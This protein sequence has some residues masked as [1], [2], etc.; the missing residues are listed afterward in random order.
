V[1]AYS[2][3]VLHNKA[4]HNCLHGCSTKPHFQGFLTIWS[5]TQPVSL[6]LRRLTSWGCVDD[7]SSIE[8]LLVWRTI[9]TWNLKHIVPVGSYAGLYQLQ[10]LF[11][12]ELCERIVFR[13][14]ET[15]G[16]E[17]WWP[18]SR[19]SVILAFGWEIGG[20]PI[21]RQDN[22]C[23]SKGSNPLL[24][25]YKSAVLPLETARTELGFSFDIRRSTVHGWAG[26]TIRTK[27]ELCLSHNPLPFLLRLPHGLVKPALNFINSPSIY[28]IALQKRMRSFATKFMSFIF[29]VSMLCIQSC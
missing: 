9:Y 22:W 3:C 8:R 21:N 1:R 6:R 28:V 29:C 5:P 13:E 26:R 2:G 23:P 14:R 19:Y 7:Y 25:G 17:R 10:L 16:Q 27:S 18:I 11:S 24:P 15:I 12:F 4:Y 20:E